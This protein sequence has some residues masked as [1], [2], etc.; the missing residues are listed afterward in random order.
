MVVNVNL[1]LTGIQQ[2][3]KPLLGAVDNLYIKDII[4]H[5]KCKI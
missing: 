4:S 5:Q 2:T 3:Q 1:L